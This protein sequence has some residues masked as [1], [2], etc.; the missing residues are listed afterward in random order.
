MGKQKR[1][2]HEARGW[3]TAIG[4]QL[5]LSTLKQILTKPVDFST[6]NDA[7]HIPTGEQVA[8][9]IATTQEK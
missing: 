2:L 3:G 9:K 7:I 8:L 5:P 6:V 4:M 1:K